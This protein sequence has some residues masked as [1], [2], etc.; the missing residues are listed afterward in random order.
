MR[1]FEN[2]MAQA[3]LEV[4]REMPSN[5]AT[6]AELR[7][8]VAEKIRLT[9]ADR[10]ENPSRPGEERWTQIMRNISAHRR[11]GFDSVGGGLRLSRR[12]AVAAARTSRKKSQRRGRRR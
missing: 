9:R 1:I 12:V 5:R 11:L 7:E 8:L 6:F 3:V 4:L 2:E 10:Q